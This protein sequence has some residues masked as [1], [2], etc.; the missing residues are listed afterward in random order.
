MSTARLSINNSEN[1]YEVVLTKEKTALGRSVKNDIILIDD[2]TSR[3]HAMIELI[4]DTYQVRDLGSANGTRLNGQKLSAPAE[5][6]LGDI[7]GVGRYYIKVLF[8]PPR[9]VEDSDELTDDDLV[10]EN[11]DGVFSAEEA[12]LVDISHLIW[13]PARMMTR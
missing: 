10:E 6:Y 12:D 11:D 7:I 4:G 8:G 13:S 2:L 1:E 9:P 3:N 5:L